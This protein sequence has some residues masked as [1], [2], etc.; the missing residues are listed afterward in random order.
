MTAARLY[1]TGVWWI[2]CHLPP[3]WRVNFILQARSLRL[4][5][6]RLGMP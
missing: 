3:Q 2:G 6:K 1:A 4:A 5:M